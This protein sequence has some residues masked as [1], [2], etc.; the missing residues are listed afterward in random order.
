MIV[1]KE[2][3]WVTK[4]DQAEESLALFTYLPSLKFVQLVYVFY[5]N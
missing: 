1:C 4:R 5:Y 3:N 2:G